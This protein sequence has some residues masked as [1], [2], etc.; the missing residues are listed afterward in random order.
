MPVQ[1]ALNHFMSALWGEVRKRC[2]KNCPE[3]LLIIK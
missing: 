3:R 1:S 2:G